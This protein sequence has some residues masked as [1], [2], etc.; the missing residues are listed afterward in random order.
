MEREFK[1]QTSL[2]SLSKHVIT[3]RWR[4]SS[5]FTRSS[6]ETI[7]YKRQIDSEPFYHLTLL[8]NKWSSLL[9]LW[10]VMHHVQVRLPQ[11]YSPRKIQRWQ[12]RI[13]KLLCNHPPRAPLPKH[14]TFLK[15]LELKFILQYLAVHLIQ[16]VE[17][18]KIMIKL[19][20]QLL[21]ILVK[22]QAQKCPTSLR[23]T[24]LLPWKKTNRNGPLSTTHFTWD[25]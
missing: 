1:R 20:Q 5:A 12:V 14:N 11:G 21:S 3:G 15:K 18:F 16:P 19:K 22:A 13:S 23:M 6:D 10:Q 9:R 24:T 8:Q 17:R 4:G 2:S 25:S 7:W